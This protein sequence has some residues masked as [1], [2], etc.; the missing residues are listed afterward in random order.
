MVKTPISTV[1][2][3]I[4]MIALVAISLWALT[5]LPEGAAVP[6]SWGADGRVTWTLPKIIGVWFTPLVALGIAAATLLR[7]RRTRYAK[8]TAVIAPVVLVFIHFLHMVMAVA[9]A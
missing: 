9:Q 1:L 6:M 7:G 5:R 3:A 4:G 8:V 2:W